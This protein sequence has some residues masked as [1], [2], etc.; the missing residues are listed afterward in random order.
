MEIAQLYK[1]KALHINELQQSNG[2]YDM[3]KKRF[4]RSRSLGQGQGLFQGH[5]YF[6]QTKIPTK[7][8]LPIPCGIQ[9]IAWARFQSSGS[10]QQRQ[11]SKSR[12]YHDIVYLKQCINFLQVKILKVR[13]TIAR[14]NQG[15]TMR[16]HIYTLANV[17]SNYHFPSP[18]SL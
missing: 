1:T 18:Y 12:S 14:S 5:S 16:L 8:Q 17:H 11:R 4:K 9:D 15:H 10:L 2:F 13:N 6:P 7:Y 3:P